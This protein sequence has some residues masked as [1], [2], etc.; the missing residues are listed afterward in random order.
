MLELRDLV[1]HYPSPGGETVKA[2]DG[3]SLVIEAGEVLALYGPSG[4][5]KSTLLMMIAGLLQPDDGTVLVRGRDV[6]KFTPREAASY[7]RADLG[8]VRQELDVLEGVSTIDNAA[9]KLLD[10]QVGWR[11]ARNRVRPLLKQLGLGDRLDHRA[12]SL[13]VGERQRVLIA[14][15]L[16][17]QPTLVLADEPT[18]SLDTQ[19]SQEVLAL[20]TDL[21]H[22]QSMAMLLVTHD[23][24]AAAFSNRVQTLRDGQLHEGPPPSSV[25]YRP[26]Q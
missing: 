15:A 18:G 2:V 14:R 3:I 10:R 7:R 9:L 1:K 17:T 11:E 19:R 20:L 26:A 8:F 13:S 21:C 5:G 22:E 12:E 23:P 16:S 4:S 6:A 25:A 24:L